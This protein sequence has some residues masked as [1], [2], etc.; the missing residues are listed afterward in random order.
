MAQSNPDRSVIEELNRR[1]RSMAL[2]TGGLFDTGEPEP[3]MPPKQPG[4]CRY[5]KQLLRLTQS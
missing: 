2:S 3:K 4:I 5:F 1:E